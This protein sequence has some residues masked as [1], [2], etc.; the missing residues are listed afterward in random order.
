M[1]APRV[2]AMDGPAASGKSSVAREVASRLGWAFVN[3]GNTYRAATWLVLQS[4]I[5]PGDADAVLRVVSEADLTCTLEDGR[6][7]VRVNGE[8]IEDKLNSE[9]V[10]GAVSL[11]ARVPQVRDKLVA[12]QRALGR[13]HPVVM[14]GR[15]IGTVVFPDALAKFY[16]DAHE[17]VRAKRRGLQG[18]SDSVGE[19]D[20]IDSTRK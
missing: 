17:D 11:V 10:N 15:D 19:R 20:R 12:L 6:S 1:S 2:I 9:A 5:D 18:H 4:G 7:V 16:I 8:N 3:T 14:E 13:A